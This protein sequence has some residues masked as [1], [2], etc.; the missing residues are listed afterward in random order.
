MEEI[1]LIDVYRQLHPTTKSF[2]YK[3]KP[4]NVRSRID[5]FLISR[6]LSNHVRKTETRNSIAPDHKSIYLNL[7][8][9]NEFKRGP[10]LWK[11]SNTLL[12]D[13][14]YKE[15]VTIKYPQILEKYSEVTEKQ[16]LWELIKMEL[17]SET[18]KYSKEKRFKLRNKEEDLQSKLQELD[19]KICNVFDHQLLE[20][21]EVAKEELKIIHETRGKEAMFRSKVKWFEQGEKPAKYFF[22]LEKRI[23]RKNGF[24]K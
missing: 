5:V 12:E 6:P 9:K 14:N 19:H 11:F 16:L 7:E 24:E 17:R 15:F 21:F 8:I 23:M 13:E 20:Q 1:N 10:G 2:T 3:S 4:L 18:I 22:N